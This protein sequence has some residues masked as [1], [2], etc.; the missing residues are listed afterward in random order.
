MRVFFPDEAKRLRNTERKSQT[1]GY[2][3][4]LV[5]NGAGAATAAAAVTTIEHL[6]RQHSMGDDENG[7]ID[8]GYSAE[9]WS[10]LEADLA[11]LTDAAVMV[12]LKL[13][14]RGA[15]VGVDARDARDVRDGFTTATGIIPRNNVDNS[16]ENS[17]E[18]CC[19][20]RETSITL[21]CCHLWFHPSRPDLKTAQCKLL[22]D[23]IE[24]FH[25][26]C[27]VR[28]VSRGER[29]GVEVEE[30]GR[31]DE[32]GLSVPSII[33]EGGKRHG[34]GGGASSSAIDPTP[35][36]SAAKTNLILCGDFNSVPVVQPE[37]LPGELQV[38]ERERSTS[39]RKDRKN[40]SS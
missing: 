37:F 8:D 25:R 9:Y 17:E 31:G 35:T 15:G 2:E 10:P 21:V 14:G 33:G 13:R 38:R 29:S 32:G 20:S 16:S 28:E 12:R 18:N 30:D 27:G 4:S 39:V 22:F 5:E 24:R 36:S 11:Q 3:P 19:S 7:G 6:G 34:G 40:D 1:A 23:A 26:E